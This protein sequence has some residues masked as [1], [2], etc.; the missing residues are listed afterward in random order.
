MPQWMENWEDFFLDCYLKKHQDLQSG[1]GAS[2]THPVLKNGP[3][4]W[5][6]CDG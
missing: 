2:K 1:F 6:F 4:T 3:I 5:Q